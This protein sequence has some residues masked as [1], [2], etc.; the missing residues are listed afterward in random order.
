[1]IFTLRL[2][3]AVKLASRLHRAQS[4]RDIHHTPYISHLMSV[5]V[6]LSSVTEN[7]DIIIAGLMH[8]S[9]EDVPGYSFEQLQRDCGENVADI[10]RHVTEPLDPN[11]PENDQLSWLSRK[12]AYLAVLKEGGIESAMVSTADKI[13]NTESFIEDL[14][15]EG[16][17]FSSRFG[18]SVLNRLWFHEQVLLIIEEKL[19][20]THS[21]TERLRTS[22]DIFR[23]LTEKE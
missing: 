5:A 12:E 22:T 14:Q 1:M 15:H 7:E 17:S 6:L 11:K 4:R 8:D 9:L 20:T 2:D 18:S 23:K 21:L 10:V 13:H 16:E 3:E 19:G